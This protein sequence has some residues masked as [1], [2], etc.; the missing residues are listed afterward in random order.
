MDAPQFRP[1]GFGEILDGAFTMYRRNFIP[2]LLT[3]LIPSLLMVGGFA[4]F[5]ARLFLR[6]SDPT[7][8]GAAMAAAGGMMLLSLV[9]ALIS[10]VMWGALTRE[11]AQAYLGRPATV[12]D[13]MR[14]A[15][16]KLLPLLGAGIAVIVLLLVTYL[17][18]AV[19]I[20]VVVALSVRNPAVA[21]LLGGVGVVLGMVAVLGLVALLFATVPAVVVEDK[22]PLQAI[23]RSFDLARGAVWRVAGLIVVSFIIVYLPVIAVAWL[24][25]SFATMANPQELPSTGQFMTQQLLSGAVGILTTPFLV[26]VIVLLYFDRRVRTEALDVQ[27]MTDRLAGAGA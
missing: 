8:V 5:G 25:G 2:F 14:T 1:L 3:A 22:G 15:F 4:V 18:L 10:I 7:D 27:L 21:L 12:G 24:T 20:G 9:A 11:S 19:V 17:A 13:G 26:S 16:R 23:S 6:Q